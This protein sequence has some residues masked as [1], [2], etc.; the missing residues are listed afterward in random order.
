M[1]T[2]YTD[3]GARGNPGPAGY[4]VYIEDEQG[5]TLAE[6]KG[7]IGEAT[8]NVSEYRALL[9][10][11]EWAVTHQVRELRVRA[12]SQLLVKQMTGE[13]SVRNPGLGRLRDRALQFVSQLDHV[14]FE[15]I[16]RDQNKQ[17]DRLANDAM[18][19]AAKLVAAE[20]RRAP[21]GSG[22]RR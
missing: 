12:D 22:A 15:H 4:G 7:M 16:R 14:E 11:L 5:Q 21:S 1:I 19:E 20:P 3:G 18:N 8:N 13:Y 10:A 6:L 17:A 9:A 2:A